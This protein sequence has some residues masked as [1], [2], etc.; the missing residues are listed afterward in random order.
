MIERE[1]PAL[2]ILDIKMEHERAGLDVLRA[3]RRQSATT[4][5]PILF[6]SAWADS[7]VLD[8]RD[9]LRAARADTMLK[10]FKFRDLLEKIGEMIASRN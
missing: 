7:L 8:E 3:V 2:V 6:V 9:E 10:P 1:R 4:A 5:I